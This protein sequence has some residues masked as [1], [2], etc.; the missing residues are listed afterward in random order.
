MI[1]GSQTATPVKT[2]VV[3]VASLS[4]ELPLSESGVAGSGVFVVPHRQFAPQL[5]AE[6]PDA[7]SSVSV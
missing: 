1:R 6:D 2:S 7:A 3:L 5:H 4:L